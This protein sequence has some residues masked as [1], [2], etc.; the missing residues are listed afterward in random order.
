L[1]EEWRTLKEV[2]KQQAYTRLTTAELYQQ[3]HYYHKEE[4]PHMLKLV[5]CA[6]TLPVH[7]ADVERS[8]STQN[9][10]CT[11]NRCTLTSEHQEMLMRVALE[12][13]DHPDFQFVTEAVDKWRSNSN[14]LLFAK[15]HANS[16]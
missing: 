1:R 16:K 4:F 15:N 13:P 5:Q 11:A 14:R 2:V 10:I 8:F 7:T 6:L 9:L 12:A 3:V